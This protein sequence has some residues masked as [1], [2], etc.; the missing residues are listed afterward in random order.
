MVSARF[1]SSRPERV[2]HYS[3]L[4]EDRLPCEAAER[5]LTRLAPRALGAIGLATCPCRLFLVGDDLATAARGGKSRPEEN[6]A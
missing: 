2:G 1:D 3:A 6:A 4:D 5:G